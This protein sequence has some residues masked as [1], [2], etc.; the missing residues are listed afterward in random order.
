MGSKT[1]DLLLTATAI[2]RVSASVLGSPDS[3]PTGAYDKGQVLA[4]RTEAA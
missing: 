2:P 1:K 4:A 3:V